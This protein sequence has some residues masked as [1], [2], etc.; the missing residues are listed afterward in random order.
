MGGLVV[1][2]CLRY[3]AAAPNAFECTPRLINSAPP[4][5]RAASDA[6]I[7]K[8]GKPPRSILPQLLH[9]PPSSARFSC[10][11]AILRQRHTRALPAQRIHNPGEILS[12]GKQVQVEPDARGM[13]ADLRE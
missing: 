9:R 7:T 2:S 12:A 10:Q 11:V 4:S 6:A 3:Q 13:P 1:D 8:P 5:T